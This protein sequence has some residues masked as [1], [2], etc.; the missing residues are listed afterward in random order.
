MGTLTIDQ[1][2]FPVTAATLWFVRNRRGDQIGWDLQI[3]ASD[4]AGLLHG[5]EIRFFAEGPTALRAGD[6]LTGVE[7]LRAQTGDTYV[8][9]VYEHHELH[10]MRLRFDDR[11]GAR[12]RMRVSATTPEGTVLEHA[13][14]LTI[15]TWVELLPDVTYQHIG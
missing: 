8:L 1:H 14:Q 5:G 7:V 12:Y 11:D 2:Q 10:D 9:A 3:R 6:D 15:D 13:A 4:E